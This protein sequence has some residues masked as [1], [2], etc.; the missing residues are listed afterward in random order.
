MYT[1]SLSL[2][3]SLYLGL[4]LLSEERQESILR[5]LREEFDSN[6]VFHHNAS[7]V[8]IIDGKSEVTS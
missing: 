3:L 5:Q 6:S 7:W 4:R 1:F 8:S 2:S